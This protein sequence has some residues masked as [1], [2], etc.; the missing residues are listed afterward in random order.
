MAAA[1]AHNPPDCNCAALR[2]A[3]RHV[4]RHYDRHMAQVGLRSSQF[5]ILTKLRRMGPLGINALAAAMGMDRTTLGRNILPLERDGLVTIGQAETD[6]RSKEVTLTKAGAEKQRAGLKH[7]QAAQ[8]GFEQTFGPKRSA[9][10]RA[11]LGEVV[12]SEFA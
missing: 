11:L 9:E 4:T 8:A 7:W 3:A 1:E 5:S 10:L 6:L 12:A 2:R